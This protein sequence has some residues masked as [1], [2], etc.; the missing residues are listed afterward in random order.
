M[1]S[2][3][4]SIAEK[5]V[6]MLGCF[7][8]KAED[9][10][11]LRSSLIAFGTKV[12]SLNTGVRGSGDFPVE[13]EAEAVAQKTDMSLDELKESSDRSLVI[14]KMGK[15]AAHIIASLLAEGKV[16]GAIG[17]G[18]GGGTYI[19]LLAMQAIPIGV[20]KFCLSTIASKDLSR[21]VGNKDVVLMPSIVDIAGL[22]SISRLLIKQA[23][24]AICGMLQAGAAAPQKNIKGS[25]AISMF[26]NTTACVEKCTD[27]LK[28]EGYEVLAFHAVGVGGKTM[29][30]LISDGFFDAVLDI[31]T[32]ELA[33]E[34]CDGICSAGPDR[35]TAA[36]K[37]GIPQVV[38][39]GCLD[40]VNYGHLDTVPE[41]F[42][43]RQ[44]FSWAPD[45]TLMR[46][47][48]EENRILAST[49]AEKLNAS[50]GE[51]AVL[52]PK[53]GISKVSSEGGVFYKPA[54]DQLLFDSL[55]DQLLPHIPV[56]EMDTHINDEAFA[57]KAVHTILN[58]L[59]HSK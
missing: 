52:L 56:E 54:V 9:F 40:M 36:S 5:T 33:D 1:L 32:T 7:D 13:F 42:K 20:P 55:K 45:V 3:P 58:M 14:E 34:L 4:H 15:G 38:V 2:P 24:G 25:I 6:L 22:N 21:Q 46:T 59:N 44:L 48:E 17:M 50:Q 41:R 53:K 37:M 27:L 43:S 10:A 26:G 12:I 16:D 39:P 35:L 51:V 11:Y 30:S 29:E 8:T 28:A 47:N 19:T 23:A 49:M 31:T 57:T 18:G